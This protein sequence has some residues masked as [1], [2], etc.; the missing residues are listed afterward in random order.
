MAS[1]FAKDVAADALTGG[2]AGSEADEVTQLKASVAELSQMLEL[3]NQVVAHREE[4]MLEW[5]LALQAMRRTCQAK[6]K[7]AKQ[8]MHSATGRRLRRKMP[9]CDSI[10]E[11]GAGDVGSS[12]VAVAELAKAAVAEARALRAAWTR[13][14]HRP[15]SQ[16]ATPLV[17]RARSRGASAT[18]TGRV[19]PCGGP[20]PAWLD[21]AAARAPGGSLRLS[22]RRSPPPPRRHPAN[23]PAPPPPR[24]TA[25]RPGTT[26][27]RQPSVVAVRPLRLRA[28]SPQV[29]P[30]PPAAAQRTWAWPPSSGGAR[31]VAVKR[32]AAPRGC[33]VPP[34]LQ[35]VV[36]RV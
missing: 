7:L 28:A 20:R 26:P 3:I 11:D 12:A 5:E 25:G 21:T 14:P 6:E 17:A 24:A 27:A 2:L 34:P 29:A 4:E 36:R 35:V 1:S 31:V 23:S 10:P 16:Q 30:A 9:P 13:L 15:P 18:F 22:V 8:Q 32:P 19:S 33:G